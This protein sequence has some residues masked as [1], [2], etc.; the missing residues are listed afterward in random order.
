MSE[1]K[2]ININA[3]STAPVIIQINLP[4]D[5]PRCVDKTVCIAELIPNYTGPH[6]N[7][8][9]DEDNRLIGIELIK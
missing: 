1:V 2:T 6:V 8:D 9:F 4:C 7:L 3:D 5:M